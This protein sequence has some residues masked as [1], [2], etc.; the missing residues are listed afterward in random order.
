MSAAKHEEKQ[1]HEISSPPSSPSPASVSRPTFIPPSTL[2]EMR[3]QGHPHPDSDWVNSTRHPLFW[4]SWQDKPVAAKLAAI[5]AA[6]DNGADP[7]S[8]DQEP[9]AAGN[10]GRPLHCAIAA[11]R[12][13]GR[14]QGNVPWAATR[15]N[16]PVIELLLE[17][18]ADPRVNGFTAAGTP[19]P[20]FL[21]SPIEEAEVNMA[22]PTGDPAEDFEEI[23]DF[24]TRAIAL[25]KAAA[26]R[27]DRELWL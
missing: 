5:R 19:G 24:Y 17:R 18:G 1:E 23:K 21:L 16:L 2:F 25:M 3:K 11:G 4:E 27:L 20:Q 8:I 15:G 14:H 9:D 26:E 6:L 22:Y 12:T 13:L 10:H 7:N